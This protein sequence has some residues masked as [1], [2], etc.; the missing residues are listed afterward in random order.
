[1]SNGVPD[2]ERLGPVVVQKNGEDIV[3]N[4]FFDDGGDG[5]KLLGQVQRFR[6]DSRYFQEKIQQLGA[7]A[8]AQRTPARRHGVSMRR[9][10]C[11]PALVPMRLAPAATIA[12]RSSRDRTPPEAFTPMA[13][14]TTRRISSTSAT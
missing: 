11:T 4:H 2:G 5:R 10:I 8:K 14:P 7:F 9:M 13:G 6:S 1:M 3:G 12:C